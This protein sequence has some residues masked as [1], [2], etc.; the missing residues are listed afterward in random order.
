MIDR[1]GDL[2]W[3]VAYGSNLRRARFQ[4]Y[5]SGGRPRGALRSY[6]GS[7]DP[8]GPRR[9]RPTRLAGALVF[10]GESTT[11]TG[12]MASFHPGASGTVLARAY[13]VTVHQFSDVVAQEIRQPPGH[14]LDPSVLRMGGPHGLGAG[15][16]D[17]LLALDCID[18]YR[19]LTISASAPAP[20]RAPAVAYLESIAAGLR[21]T[22]DLTADE[23]A[24]YLLAAGGVD[25]AWTRAGLRD[26]S[27]ARP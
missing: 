20:P 9:V 7:R 12:G 6:P 10:S 23:I 19:A 4:C 24:D 17:T 8:A 14:D 27:A 16:Y 26:L 13:L 3:Y 25:G 2:T 11:W 1:D 15:H 5:L 21:E 22:F 18:G